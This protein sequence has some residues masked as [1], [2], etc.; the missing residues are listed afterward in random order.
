[1]APVPV[2]PVVLVASGISPS[3]LVATA[4]SGLPTSV[5]STR[6]CLNGGCG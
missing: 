2:S 3:Q 1:M 6:V 5:G 4:D